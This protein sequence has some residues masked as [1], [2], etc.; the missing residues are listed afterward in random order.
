MQKP[1]SDERTTT[2]GGM[3]LT[4]Q[5]SGLCLTADA[6]L[7]AAFCR[8]K[9]GDAA[10]EFGCGGGAV[11]LL[12][13]RRGVYAKIVAVERDKSL[14]DLACRNVEQNGF[15]NTV[16]PLL[17]DVR[18]LSPAFFGGPLD[19]VLT[20]P[21]YFDVAAGRPSPSAARQSARHG[22]AGDVF[23]FAAAAARC[24]KAGGR[25]VTVWRPDRLATLFAALEQSDLAPKRMAFVAPHQKAAPALVLTE[26]V[27]G[28]GEGLA[29][30]P[31]LFLK[32]SA[33]PGAED[34]AEAAALYRTGAWPV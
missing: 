26:A 13:A 14:Y 28:G 5:K 7:L 30:L 6:L 32:T 3:R 23:D 2:V 4:E 34:T 20:N 31:T 33:D 27:R 8:G 22:T 15:S 21:P 9:K 10:A 19:A 11:S 18:D 12:L 24:L 29:L 16:T 17:A 25:F 1:Q